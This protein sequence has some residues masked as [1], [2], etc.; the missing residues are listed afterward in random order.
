MDLIC[1]WVSI[2]LQMSTCLQR[3]SELKC[4][5]MRHDPFAN[6]CGFICKWDVT[7]LQM[8]SLD[9]PPPGGAGSVVAMA[10]AMA[11]AVP[12]WVAMM[13]AAVVATAGVAPA[14]VPVKKCTDIHLFWQLPLLLTY[15]PFTFKPQHIS[16]PS[17]T[18]YP[19]DENLS[20]SEQM[21]TDKC[22]LLATNHMSLI[23]QCQV[24]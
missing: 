2:H 11:V 5:Q 7:Y 9:C 22:P 19:N 21:G 12:V 6:E 18:Y 16:V 17:G 3:R 10:V 23:Y 13:T 1:K 14:V 8:N 24:M 15:Q 20:W 4:M